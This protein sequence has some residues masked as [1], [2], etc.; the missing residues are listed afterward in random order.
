[1]NRLQKRLGLR[2]GE[3]LFIASSEFGECGLG[4]VHALI[5]FDS[6]RRKG[7]IHRFEKCKKIKYAVSDIAIEM[8]SN[9]TRVGIER[10]KKSAIEQKRKLSYVCKV[11]FGRDY[12]HCFFPKWIKAS[13]K[14]MPH[15]LH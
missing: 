4:H 8:F 5:S 15:I 11:E 3:L 1:M 9:S 10:V 6:L 12:K 7:K 2:K 14:Y 13:R